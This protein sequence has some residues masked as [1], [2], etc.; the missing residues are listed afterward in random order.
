MKLIKLIKICLTCLAFAVLCGVAQAQPVNLLGNPGFE[1]Y[2]IGKYTNFDAGGPTPYWSDDGVNYTNTGIE[3]AGAHS[4]TYRA[5]EMKGDDGAYQISTNLVPLQIGQQII[6]T[7]WALGDTS[8]DPQGTNPTDPTQIVGILTSTN[9]QGN[10]P[11]VNDPFTD[12]TAVL[13]STNGLPNGWAQYS[14]TYTVTPADTNKYPGV[15]F[16]TGEVATNT[17][18]V[19]ADYDDFALYV[20]PVGGLPIIINSPASQTTPLGGN[21]SFTVLAVNATGYQW[22]A[23]AP[24]SGVYTNLVEG[25]IFAGTTTTNLTL[26]GVTTNQ[27][28]DIVV[29]ASN[30]SGS[31]TSAPPANLTVAGLIY[32]ET[33]GVP[34][35]QDQPISNVGW[36]NDISG[37]NYRL[38]TG[39]GGLTF[40]RCAVYSSDADNSLETFWATTLTANGGPYENGRVTNKMAFP[41]I[42]LATVFNLSFSLAMNANGAGT[43]RGFLAVQLNNN[44]WY[45]STNNSVSTNEWLPKATSATFVTDNIKFNPSA[46]T[47]NQL[48][49]SPDGSYYKTWNAT[50]P[51]PQIGLP[52]TADLT[53]YITG[54]GVVIIHT[55]HGDVQFD[56]FTV[57]GA[58]PFTPLPLISAAPFSQ[59]NYAHSTTT[60]I[61]AATTNGQT[62]GLT[63]QWQTNTAVG[64]TNWATLSN[65]GQFSGSGTAILSITNVTAAANQKDYRVIVTDGAGSITSTPPATL[66]IVDSAPIPSAGTA[67]YPDAQTGFATI[68]MTNE[69]N[70]NNTVNFTASFVGTQPI[71]YQWQVSPNA[72]GSSA[73]N[74]PGATNATYT[75]SNPQV[76]N[77]GYYSLQ[78][79][80]SI[81][82]A[83]PTNSALVQ[84]VMLPSTNAVIHWSAPVVIGAIGGSN[85]LTAAQILGLPGTFYEAESFHAATVV[86]VTNGTAVFSFG[87]TGA[88]ASLVG[89]FTGRKTGVYTGPGTGDTNLDLV[90]SSDDEDSYNGTPAIPPTITLNNLIIGNLYTVQLFAIND[91]AGFLRATI[92]APTTDPADVSGAFQMGDNVYVVGTFIATGTTQAIYQNEADGHGYISCLIVR[93]LSVPPSPTIQKS[94]SNLLVNWQIGSLLEATN[95]KGPWITNA[96]PEPITI[97]PAGSSMFFR[98]QVP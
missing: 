2:D 69:V 72:D 76:S 66:T 31:V 94:G 67:I 60:F 9:S 45:V 23:G 47:W 43:Y 16:N 35:T 41:G 7:W 90:L 55:V 89:G 61:V 50:N 78:A 54:I 88:S 17:E 71:H 46:S 48:T 63:Y 91:T 44:S 68:A 81:S 70:N 3:N 65:G 5:W 33:F 93:T 15:F 42:N 28:M 32:Y 64:S 58:I 62:A 10:P 98:V 82:G 11:Y 21:L 96:N 30:G 75:L 39:N 79:S 85:G 20:V 80:N 56:N 8:S 86:L 24:G 92:F 22:M 83:T 97:A 37:N 73:V 27:N 57:L 77:T 36:R 52:A 95:L 29:V 13:I 59:T 18:G 74:V 38:F 49:V 25:G 87:N 6:L 19:F 34:T 1:A 14:L 4:G 26:T 53:G 51:Y 84:Y 12:T 40:P